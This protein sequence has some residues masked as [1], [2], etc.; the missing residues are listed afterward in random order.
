MRN[1][2]TSHPRD[3]GETYFEH[4]LFACRYGAKM[5]LGGL[6]ALV[7][8]VFPFLFQTTGS[9]ITRELGATLDESRAR[10]AA[11]TPITE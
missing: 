10:A 9:R 5:T 3:V 11:R 2:F 7:H 6:A 8:G 1:P 4:G